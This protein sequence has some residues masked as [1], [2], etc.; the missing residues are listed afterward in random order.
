MSCISRRHP[1]GRRSAALAITC[2]L[3][4]FSAASAGAT[5]STA[6]RTKP[7][8]ILKV[9]VTIRQAPETSP[10]GGASTLIKAFFSENPLNVGPVIF[11]I[12]NLTNGNRT[13]V[14]NGVSSRSMGPDGGTAVMR[15][16]FKHPGIYIVGVAS[17]DNFASNTGEIK[18]IR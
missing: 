7:R 18:V 4:A 11:V 10:G 8:T 3:A 6:D 2:V 17:T 15:V 16:T 1:M 5:E 9:N 12:R 14:L 13:L